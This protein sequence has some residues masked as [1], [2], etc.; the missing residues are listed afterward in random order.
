MHNNIELI[1]TLTLGLTSAT[2]LGYVMHRLGFSAIIGYLLAGVAV[3]PNTPGFVANHELAEQLAELGVILLMFGVGLNLHFNELWAVRRIA[4]VGAT[5]QIISAI[6]LGMLVGKYFGWSWKSGFVYG[7]AISVASTVVLVRL[8]TD[9]KELH[10]PCGH[11][12]IGWL[13]VEDLLTVIMLVL[14]PAVFGAENM[15]GD[16]LFL[17]IFL[18]ILKLSA[19]VALTFIIGGNVIPWV[20]KK[21]AETK[22][23]EL[24][25]LSILVIA[26]GIAV[27]SAKIFDVSMALGAFLAGMIVGRSTF[28]LRAAIEAL[29]MKDAFA[30]LFFVS[31]GMLFDPGS[32]LTSPTL[33]LGTILVVA[34]GKPLS[35]IIIILLLRY[36]LKIAF[37]VGIAL[38]QIGEFSFMLAT[39]GKSLNLLNDDAMNALLAASILSISINPLLHDLLIGRVYRTILEQPKLAKIAKKL[40]ISKLEK[41]ATISAPVEIHSDRHHAIVVGYGPVGETICHILMENNIDPIVIEM[42]ID[43]INKLKQQ[44]ITAIYGDAC[45]REVLL[46]SRIE[47]ARGMLLSPADISHAAEI[48]RLSRELNPNLQIL[49]RCSYIQ[50]LNELRKVGADHA[51]S[52][53]GEVAL[54]ITEHILLK[55]GAT[56]EQIDHE[57]E[58]IHKKL[59][60][61]E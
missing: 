41:E 34:L 19:M 28:S 39:L 30:V 60:L 37:H 32:I 56:L 21:I 5:L 6:I 57:R 29:P 49:V 51:F 26:L 17:L 14:L 61:N 33:I 24:F 9:K 11:I 59:F 7:M 52:E 53:E 20:L 47:S 2:F 27:L 48:I 43:T 1:T 45:Q 23:R 3:G 36:P 50:E 31:T 44:G 15:K 22:S 58:R 25:T 46:A 54:A 16:H 12:A 10:T 40:T 55:L 35:A 38:G 13:V 42:N 4:I 8:L 18:T